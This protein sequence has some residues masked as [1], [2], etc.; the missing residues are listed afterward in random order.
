[1]QNNSKKLIFKYFKIVKQRTG[2]N[3]HATNAPIQ[4]NPI[5]LE[6]DVQLLVDD[7]RRRVID[8]GHRDD[9]FR[10]SGQSGLAPVDCQDR[11]LVL[12]PLELRFH[13]CFFI[14]IRIQI[15][16]VDGYL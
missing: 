2:I 8:V 6:L 9:D 16:S 3:S 13:C 4:F 15:Y 11:E 5:H 7:P 10:G 12:G 14:I 1:M